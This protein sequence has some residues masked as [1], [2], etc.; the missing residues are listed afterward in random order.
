M[1]VL[2]RGVVV[3]A[4]AGFKSG[5]DIITVVVVDDLL[6]KDCPNLFNVSPAKCSMSEPGLYRSY[7]SAFQASQSGR[8]NSLFPGS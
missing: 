1:R 6:L 4:S 7:A 5:Q 3:Y 2:D 8:K